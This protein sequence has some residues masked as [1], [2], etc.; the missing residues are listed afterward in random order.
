MKPSPWILAQPVADARIRLF[1]FPFSGGSAAAFV[2]WQTAL[3]PGIH[4]CAIQPPGRGT[5]FG[6]VP[7]VDWAPML[8]DLV[9][10]LRHWDDLPCAFFGHSLGGLVAFEL[11]RA[12]S[13]DHAPVPRHLFISATNAPQT[14]PNRPDVTRMDDQALKARLREYNGT[15]AEI[16]ENHEL[17]ELLLPCIRA[18]LTLLQNYRYE[19]RPRLRVPITLLA[20]TEDPHLVHAELPTWRNETNANFCQH[21]F[22]GNHFYLQP[23]RE[24]VL[25]LLRETLIDL[26]EAYSGGRTHRA[27]LS[28]GS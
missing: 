18:D 22:T 23:E 3:G 13:Q 19:T 11:A 5:R 10:T 20:G 8:E 9:R 14:K 15:P 24:K 12:C 4:V 21:Y 25:A 2:N 6:E 7:Y 16:L 28:A 26:A 27:D 17:M 1:C